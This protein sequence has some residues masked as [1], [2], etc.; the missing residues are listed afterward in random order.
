MKTEK[1][2]QKK[3]KKVAMVA[4]FIPEKDLERMDEIIKKY[5]FSSRY[6]LLKYLV[7]CFLK[8]ADPLPGEVANRD[9]EEMFEGYEASSSEDFNDTKR[10]GV[11]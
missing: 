8:V 7:H 3:S 4:T 1:D 2:L 5:R 10:G 9:I 11:I 6:Q